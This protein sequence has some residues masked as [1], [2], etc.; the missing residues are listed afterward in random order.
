M[1][2]TIADNT[3]YLLAQ[4]LDLFES[5]AA[6]LEDYYDAGIEPCAFDTVSKNFNQYFIDEQLALYEDLST[7]PWL[8]ASAIYVYYDD[9]FNGTYGGDTDSMEL[10]AISLSYG[11]APETGTTT[12]LQAFWDN[13]NLLTGGFSGVNYSVAE[14]GVIV[15]DTDSD[16]D[17]EKTFTC[18]YDLDT[19]PILVRQ[20]GCSPT[21][22]STHCIDGILALT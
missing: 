18:E 15:L 16:I 4:I 14:G 7:A 19:I 9:I 22:A 17:F 11:I 5:Y 21:D 13:W 1:E 8:K 20:D 12:Q 2:V 10:A 6:G 3:S